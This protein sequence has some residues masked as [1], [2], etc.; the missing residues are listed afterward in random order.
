MADEKEDI[1]KK[2]PLTIGEK[3]ESLLSEKEAKKKFKDTEGRIGGSAKE[4]RALGQIMVGNLEELEKDAVTARQT[5][6]KD[7][8]YPAVNVAE[9]MDKGVSSGTTFLKVKAREFMGTTPPDNAIARRAYVGFIEWFTSE[10]EDVIDRKKLMELFGAV[11]SVLPSVVIRILNPEAEAV[12]EQQK[13]NAKEMWDKHNRL[14][15]ELEKQRLDIVAQLATAGFGAPWQAPED[16][17]LRI[18][19]KK[20]SEQYDIARQNRSRNEIW[21]LTDTEITILEQ[22]GFEIPSSEKSGDAGNG[23]L[24]FLFGSRFYK[25]IKHNTYK[26]PTIAKAYNDAEKYDGITQEASDEHLAKNLPWFDE[27]IAK[28]ENEIGF[29]NTKPNKAALLV[30]YPDKHSQPGIGFWRGNLGF[31]SGKKHYFW[32]DVIN[33]APLLEKYIRLYTD[34]LQESLSKA[35]KDRLDLLERWKPTAPDWSWTGAS[36]DRKTGVKRTEITANSGVPL[37][38]IKRTG[39]LPVETTLIDTN[40]KVQDFFKNI[41]GVTRIEYGLSI[42][43]TEKQEHIRHFSSAL[44]DMHEILNWDLPEAISWGNLGIKFASS[45]RGKASAHY[46]AARVA[47]NLTRGRGDGTVAH[48]YAHYIDNMLARKLGRSGFLSDYIYKHL[49]YVKYNEVDMAMEALFDYIINAK[50][51]NPEGVKIKRVFDAGERD[52]KSY[53]WQVQGIIKDTI[54]ETF[55]AAKNRFSQLKWIHNVNKKN[56]RTFLRDMVRHFG[57][58]S[59]A[60]EFGARTTL[61]YANS[62]EMSSDYWSRPHELFARAFETYIYDKLETKNRVNNYLVSGAYFGREEGVYPFGEERERIFVLMNQLMQAIKNQFGVPDFKAFTDQRVD[63]F[64]ELDKE[65]NE[66]T[67]VMVDIETE[68]VVQVSGEEHIE[69]AKKKIKHLIDLL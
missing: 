63:E 33:D 4:A 23:L 52:L 22:T 25:F 49:R 43:D 6:K 64:I 10:I 61:Y 24:E 54:E 7:K 8:V 40:E 39:G 62:E 21:R 68:E 65:G 16:H 9:Q 26:Q 60:F 31:S 32:D 12:I 17:P 20:I 30:F 57:H 59:Y 11:H 19:L 18:G 44:L 37:S 35:Q 50:G 41:L 51:A 58:K 47:I 46:E 36:N 67:A 15:L 55:E 29:L 14:A 66:E 42:T 48:E 69:S 45:G 38:Y 2:E 3:V 5:V 13:A 53:S 27:R 28:Y 34:H 1:E 56:N